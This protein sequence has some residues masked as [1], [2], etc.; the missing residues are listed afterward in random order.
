MFFSTFKCSGSLTLY[1]HGPPVD[2]TGLHEPPGGCQRAER[3]MEKEFSKIDVY[4]K[5]SFDLAV[6]FFFP[7]SGCSLKKKKKKKVFLSSPIKVGDKKK[8]K[9]LFSESTLITDA[10]VCS[11]RGALSSELLE[12]NPLFRLYWPK[13]ILNISSFDFRKRLANPLGW[14]HAPPGRSCAPVK[15][16][17]VK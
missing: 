2:V 8:L 16:P 14:T 15:E 9:T 1:P 3:C 13:L 17:L 7:N 11:P 10:L 12:I 5:E 4:N 6:H